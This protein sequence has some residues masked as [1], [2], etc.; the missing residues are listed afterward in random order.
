MKRILAYQFRFFLLL[1][2][3]PLLLYAVSIIGCRPASGNEVSPSPPITLLPSPDATEA[4]IRSLWSD[5]PHA[6]TYSL[7]KGPNT[8]CARCHAPGNWDPAATI[9]PP[10]NCVSCKFTFEAEP[11]VAQGNPL[12]PQDEWQNIGCDV[13]HRSENGVTLAEVAWLN[14]QTGYYE[15]ITTA[16]QL[17]QKCH[18]DTATIRHQR[19]LGAAAHA[20]YVCTDCHDPHTTRAN[21][22]ECHDDVITAAVPISGHDEAHAAVTCVA[23][24]DAAGLEAGPFESEQVW[25]TFRTTLLLGRESTNPYQSHA[26]QREVDCSRCHYAENPWLLSDSVATPAP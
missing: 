11:R 25:I 24:H 22:L 13:C 26:L 6:N 9:D 3:L 15:T 7:E 1:T 10:P 18:V 20:D 23:C 16:T 17:C 5:S 4:A 2:W 8:Y 12:V 19:D 21:C 14:Q